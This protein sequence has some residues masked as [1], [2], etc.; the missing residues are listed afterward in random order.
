MN[1]KIADKKFCL[2]TDDGRSGGRPVEAVVERAVRG[3]AL[4]AL[5]RP[6]GLTDAEFLRV[7]RR[8]REITAAGG[9]LLIINDR[10]DIAALCGADG[11]HLGAGDL[12]PG[13]ARALL[14]RGAVVGFSAHSRADVRAAREAGADYV[15]LSPLFATTSGGGK[16]GMGLERW[17]EMAEGAAVPVYALGGVRVENVEDLRCAGV[18]RVAVAS[19][20]TAA[21]DIERAARWFSEA[22]N[23]PPGETACFV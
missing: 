10:V 14:G 18:E 21:D 16:K 17:L 11:V 2:V 8:L 6:H 3:G 7:A 1:P 12:P 5:Y 4:M 13:D 23:R 20:I 15:T 22:M 9:A 19:A